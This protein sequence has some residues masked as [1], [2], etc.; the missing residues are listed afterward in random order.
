MAVSIV[1]MFGEGITQGS[2]V[3]S[4]YSSRVQPSMAIDLEVRAET[5]RVVEQPRQL[6]DGHPVPQRNRIQADERL[7]PALEHRPF[8]RHAPDGIRPIAHDDR[9]LEARRALQA[10]GH[11][12]DEGVDA[13]ADVLQVDD[14]DVEVPQHR[15]G[16]LPRFAVERVDR[17]AWRAVAAVRRLDH[18]VLQVGVEAVLR[19]ED[20]G[21][22]HAFGAREPIADMDELGVDRGRVGDDADA[23]AAEAS[24]DEQACGSERDGHK[25][26]IGLRATGYRLR[27]LQEPFRKPP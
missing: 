2:P 1:G 18:V 5:E 27:A 13:R 7:E 14:E 23:T 3:V 15:L 19:T 25:R 26:C 20:R 16:R 21:E 17:H 22:R 11:R 24:R 12:V 4:Q 10:V 9:H 8:D 6:P